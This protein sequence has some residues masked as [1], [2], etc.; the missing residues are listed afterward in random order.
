MTCIFTRKDIGT[1]FIEN[2]KQVDRNQ[3][4]QSQKKLLHFFQKQISS[5]S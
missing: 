4:G 3:K 1:V 2:K 5:R